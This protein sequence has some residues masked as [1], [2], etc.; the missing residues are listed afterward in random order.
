MKEIGFCLGLT[1]FACS[2]APSPPA[3]SLAP[4]T[5]T[6]APA[7][8]ARS[9]SSASAPSSASVLQPESS[10]SSPSEASAPG[11]RGVT[12]GASAEGSS[13][14]S[15]RSGLAPGLSTNW[16][17]RDAQGATRPLVSGDT[18]RSGDH[19]WLE[20]SAHEPLYVYVVYVSA[21]GAA[22]VLYPS[23]G[24]LLLGA[25]NTQRLPETQDFE[26]DQR[27]GVERV[28]VVA[29]RDVLVR[30]ASTLADLVKRVRATH[31]FSGTTKEAGAK[32]ASRA[33]APPPKAA[34]PPS[35]VAP[36]LYTGPTNTLEPSYAGVDTRGI[37]LSGSPRGRVDVVP[38]SDG[39]IAI[40]LLIEHVK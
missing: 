37:V 40:P 10:T 21:D 39:V 9:A 8:D 13:N 26:L 25:G 34:P 16:T 3:A 2:G 38:D 19:F 30:S 28:L 29:S 4:A 35:A 27:P 18:L 11:T 23:Q 17:A 20:L 15:Q 14:A 33:T 5:P 6:T 36:Q 31:R 24:D 12:L 7:S 32:A 1:L 22:S